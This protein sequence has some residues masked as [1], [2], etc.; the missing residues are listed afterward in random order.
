MRIIF[1]LIALFL[2]LCSFGQKSELKE[3]CR[4]LDAT[5]NQDKPVHMHYDLTIVGKKGG[6][7]K[8]AIA[9]DWYKKGD[10]QRMVMGNMQEVVKERN[11]VMVVN[12]LQKTISV[13]ND[14]SGKF[15]FSVVKE[16]NSFIDSAATVSKTIESGTEKYILTYPAGY[17]YSKVE[18]SFSSKTKSLLKIYTLFTPADY[19]P[20]HSMEVSYSVW[21]TNWKPDTGF[22]HMEKYLERSGTTFRLQESCKAYRLFQPQN[23]KLN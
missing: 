18:L 6:E 20:Y 3:L 17:V 8:A 9:M 4:E 11:T 2:T 13:E 23:G 7:D 15:T 19:Q 1:S 5:L 21:N 12:H 10:K 14:T 22:P 16:L